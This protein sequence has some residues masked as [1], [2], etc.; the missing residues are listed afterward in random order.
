MPSGILNHFHTFVKSEI[1]LIS[2]YE[3]A[4]FVN[5]IMTTGG[6][7]PKSLSYLCGELEDQVIG[8]VT[9]MVERVR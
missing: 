5:K 9:Y 8:E 2:C 4:L 3:R 6:E 7:I 1:V